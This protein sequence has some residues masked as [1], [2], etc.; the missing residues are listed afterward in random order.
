MNQKQLFEKIQRIQQQLMQGLIEREQTIKLAFLATLSGEHILLIGPPGTGKSMVARRI[1]LMFKETPYFERLLT[2]FSVPEELFGPLSIKALEQDQ[3]TRLTQG[4]LPQAS[5]AFLD[6]IFKANSAILNALLTLLNE[7]EFDNGI[8][9]EKA[10]LLSVVGASNELPE[11]EEL[12]ALFDRFL[13]RQY[14][15]PV[16]RQGFK[17]LLTLKNNDQDLNI[18]QLSLEEVQFIQNNAN[19]IELSAEVVNF[20]VELRKWCHENQIQVSDRRWRKIVH[21]LKVSAFTNGQSTVSIWDCWL[22]QHCI[23]EKPEQVALVAEMYEQYCGKAVINVDNLIKVVTALENEAGKLSRSKKSQ[24]TNHIKSH[25][26]SVY[27]LSQINQNNGLGLI[28]VN[29]PN[30]KNPNFA[31]IKKWFGTEKSAF[32]KG[33]IICQLS[34]EKM[35]IDIF[36][37]CDGILTFRPAIAVGAKLNANATVIHFSYL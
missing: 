30:L 17:Q 24:N 35:E 37:P 1:H 25:Q 4:Y 31:T 15:A 2:R 26:E 32:K 13:F 16:S 27:S 9:R 6:E 11:S 21:M 3:Y 7:R 28:K 22:V 29:L 10:P 8:I 20:L 5:I 12:S 19:H 23:W 34:Y 14:V 33:E 36:A 18:E